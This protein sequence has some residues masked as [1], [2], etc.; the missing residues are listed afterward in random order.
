MPGR[1]VRS[2]QRHREAR[3]LLRSAGPGAGAGGVEGLQAGRAGIPW[4]R[5]ASWVRCVPGPCWAEQPLALPHSAPRLRRETAFMRDSS[6]NRTSPWDPAREVLGRP[7]GE[8]VP[9]RL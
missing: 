7:G 8:P 4:P 1:A 5:E 6:A 2:E 3:G 9:V